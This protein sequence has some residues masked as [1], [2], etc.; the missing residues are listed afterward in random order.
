MESAAMQPRIGLERVEIQ[1]QRLD[2][3]ETVV[4]DSCPASNFHEF[5]WIGQVGIR[6]KDVSQSAQTMTPMN[7]GLELHRTDGKRTIAMIDGKVRKDP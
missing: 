7:I 5:R 1:A 3:Q 4:V 2:T 6:L